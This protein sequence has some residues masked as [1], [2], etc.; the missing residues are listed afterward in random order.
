MERLRDTFRHLDSFAIG[1]AIGL[2]TVAMP[3]TT[4]DLVR[5][6]DADS[7]MSL[8]GSLW[9]VFIRGVVPMSAGAGIALWARSRVSATSHR[10]TFWRSIASG[11]SA[12]ALLAGLDRLAGLNQVPVGDI[13]RFAVL[14]A[15]GAAGVLVS[16]ARLPRRSLEPAPAPPASR[17]N[18]EL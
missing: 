2:L 4:A 11:F 10:A 13:E 17:P 9:N 16:F 12:A 14:A 3:E 15:A 7:F 5:V 18:V 6:A 8:L 1:T